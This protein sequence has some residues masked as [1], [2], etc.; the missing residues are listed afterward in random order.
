MSGNILTMPWD[1]LRPLIRLLAPEIGRLARLG[2]AFARKVYERYVYAANH[3]NDVVAN[4][5]LRIAVE[6][7][8]KRDLTI[9]ERFELGSKYG[10]LLEEKPTGPRIVVPGTVTKQ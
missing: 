7:Y 3:P 10:H 4:R 1:E 9:V 5:E 8:L 2:D 6:D